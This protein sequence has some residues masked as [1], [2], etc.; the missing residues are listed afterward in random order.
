M[1]FRVSARG[2]V[3]LRQ[4]QGHRIKE[5]TDVPRSLLVLSPLPQ[6]PL[7]ITMAQSMHSERTAQ[8]EV[9]SGQD[10]TQI[11]PG[12]QSQICFLAV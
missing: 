2:Q 4:E 10:K 3:K 12:F 11:L 8:D 9:N 1:K 5:V 7:Y 6:S